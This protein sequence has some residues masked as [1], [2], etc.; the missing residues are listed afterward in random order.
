MGDVCISAY[1]CRYGKHPEACECGE[2]EGKCQMVV[3]P[4]VYTLIYDTYVNP[5][6]KREEYCIHWMPI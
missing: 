2:C 5:R 3:G 6:K 4:A 1:P